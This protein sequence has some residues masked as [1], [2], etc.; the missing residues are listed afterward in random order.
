VAGSW[1]KICVTKRTE[2]NLLAEKMTH[3]SRSSKGRTHVI[4]LLRIQA[5]A[6]G[7]NMPDIRRGLMT[8]LHDSVNNSVDTVNYKTVSYRKQIAPQHLSRSNDMSKRI[9]RSQI[10]GPGYAVPSLRLRAWRT[11]QKLLPSSNLVPCKRWLLYVIL[12]TKL[13][14]ICK[15]WCLALSLSCRGMIDRKWLTVNGLP[16]FGSLGQTV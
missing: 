10:F 1:K 7:C 14:K 6:H 13:Q 2:P 5:T 15:C 4:K 8:V 11:M 9:V 12:C 16:K 3:L